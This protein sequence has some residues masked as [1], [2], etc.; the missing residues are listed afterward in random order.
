MY[1][2]SPAHRCEMQDLLHMS[3][4]VADP[5]GRDVEFSEPAE[6]ASSPAGGLTRGGATVLK[7]GGTIERKNFFDPSTFCIP[8]GYRK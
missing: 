4:A 5:G 6:G 2:A 3:H 8:G 7:V 1:T